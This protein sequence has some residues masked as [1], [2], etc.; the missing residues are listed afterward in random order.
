MDGVALLDLT[1]RQLSLNGLNSIIGRGVVVHQGED[2]LGRVRTLVHLS[3]YLYVYL[4]FFIYFYPS[5]HLSP[6]YTFIYPSINLSI[7]SFIYPSIYP[8]TYLS[9]YLLSILPS[10]VL[11]L[12]LSRSVLLSIRVRPSIYHNLPTSTY[13]FLCCREGTREACRLGTPAAG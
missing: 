8:S 6:T 12:L 4:S 7:C 10:I 11:F 13:I 5:V 9:I 2:D 1:D 3:F